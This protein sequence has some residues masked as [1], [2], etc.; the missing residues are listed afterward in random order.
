MRLIKKTFLV[1][2]GLIIVVVTSILLVLY[3]AMPIYYTKVK[4]KEVKREFDQTSKQIK[5]KTV[6]EIRDILTKKINKDNI[7]Y[8]LVDSDNQ[9]LYP[10]LQLLDGVSESKD[11]QNVNIVTTFD[12]SYSNVKVMSQKVTLRDGKKMTLLGQSSLQPVT[13]ASKVLLDLYPSLLIFSVT[14]GSIVAYLYS[15]T[16]SRRILSMSQ[17]AKKMVNLEPNLTCTIHGKDEIAMLASDINRLYASLSTS[18]KS[19]QKEYEKAS[20]S[21][22]EKSEFL[23]MTSH[24]LKTPITSVIGMIDGMLYNVGDFADRDKYLRKCR[25]VLEGQAQL[26]QSILSLSKIETLASQN[27][28]LFSL[29]SSLEEEMEVFLVLSELKHLKVIINLEEQFVKANKVYLLKAI[30]NII[31]NAFHYTKPGGQVMIQLKDNQLVIKNEAET[32]LTQQQMKQLFQPFYRPDYSRNRKDGGTGLGLFITHQILDQ[33]HLAYRFVVL[34]QRW[35]V[36]TIDF[37]SHHDD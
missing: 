35:M 14:V 26:V 2:N 12:N 32:L 8:S 33:H 21:E 29:K 6:T 3:F 31:D 7:W 18:I 34:D 4:D 22:R 20:D 23:R 37:P 11:S 9:L 28:E 17:T 16:S 27:Q 30:K 13:D 24:E 15:R 1:I 36:F 10:S 19:L 25:D 5:G